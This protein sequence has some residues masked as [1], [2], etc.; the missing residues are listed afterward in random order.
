MPEEK[1]FSLPDY[2]VFDPTSDH[3][4]PATLR[5]VAQKLS[6]PLSS[7]DQQDIALL[8]HKFD[9][10]K[11]IFG[12]ASPQIGISKQIIIFSVLYTPELKK[13]RPDLT[14]TMPKTVWVNPIYK[15]LDDFGYSKDYEGC[16]SVKSY[17]GKVVRHNTIYYEAYTPTG[18]LTHGTA[19]GYLARILQ[20]E[21][22]HLNG[23]LFIDR[24][25]DKGELITK[26]EYKRMREQGRE[27]RQQP[28]NT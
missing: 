19:N 4:V 1:Y 7:E 8:T 14:D 9:M 15:G 18:Q 23:I 12:L 17:A 25:K 28:E 6:F 10:E 21:I 16:F 26:E 20:H 27:K 3:K 5:S 11:P 13:W 24:I 22:D 2:V